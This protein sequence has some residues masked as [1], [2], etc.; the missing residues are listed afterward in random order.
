MYRFSCMMIHAALAFFLFCG[1][2]SAQQPAE[3]QAQSKQT[4]I[5]VLLVDPKNPVLPAR[6]EKLRKL[7]EKKEAETIIAN[8]RFSG[9]IEVYKGEKGIYIVN[10]MPLEE[11]VKGVIVSEVGSSWDA[12]ALKA[13]AVAARTYAIFQMQNAH[14]SSAGYHL[15]SS[16]LHQ[17]YKGGSVPESILKAVDETKDQVILF[18]GKPI[19]A[20][21]HS[22]SG[23]MTEDPQEV[24]GKQYPYLKVVETNSELSPFYMWQRKIPVAEIE[25]ALDIKGIKNISIF[26]LTSSMRSKELKILNTDKEFIVP[27]KDFRRKIGWDKLPSTLITGMNMQNGSMVFEGRGY[28]HGVGLCQW[29]SLQ[30]AKEGKSYREI[31][32]KFYPGTV[33]EHYVVP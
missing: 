1:I 19:I 23:G 26:S 20:Y 11:Y 9:T 31:L 8:A 10:E 16:V 2:S 25:K 32:Q 33:I 6:D 4:T 7:D 24:F 21:Y 28:G 29:S 30:M 13:Q 22:T 5:R 3:P 17:V 18:D 12:E 15:T 27:A 14:R